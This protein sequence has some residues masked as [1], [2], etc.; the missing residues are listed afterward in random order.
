MAHVLLVDDDAS[1]T[2]SVKEWL[3]FNMHNVRICHSAAEA[4]DAL[5]SESF[6]VAVFDWEL[7][8]GQGINICRWLRTNGKSL[9]VLMLTGKSKI[10][11]KVAGFDAGADDYLTKPF[12]FKE[13]LARLDALLRRATP[14][15]A[16]STIVYRN[17]KLD[18]VGRRVWRDGEEIALQRLEFKVLEFLLKN[19]NKVFSPEAL[20]SQ[21]WQDDAD[22]SPDTVRTCIKKLRK[23]ID[24]VAA[25]SIIKNVHGV[26]YR[27]DGD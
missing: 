25:E 8:D 15:A 23:K 10:E 19:R 9:P 22:V 21:L 3:S 5:K 18:P 7:P 4:F 1:L 13:L 24:S 11:E 6:D 17:V 14:A 16:D 27:V 26:G 20:L 2:D 12:H